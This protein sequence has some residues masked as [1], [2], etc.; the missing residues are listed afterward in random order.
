MVVSNGQSTGWTSAVQGGDGP[1]AAG[2]IVGC[3][4]VAGRAALAIRKIA[5]GHILLG[6]QGGQRAHKRR[7]SKAEMRIGAV[8]LQVPHGREAEGGM[9]VLDSVR[10][11]DRPTGGKQQL[12]DRDTIAAAFGVYV[13]HLAELTDHG[14]LLGCQPSQIS[15]DR[16][17]PARAQNG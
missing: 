12:E 14:V 2:S 10:E 13:I 16:D 15:K 17:C 4:L 7:I 8:E 6:S 9:P 3:G 11:R 1:A 5:G